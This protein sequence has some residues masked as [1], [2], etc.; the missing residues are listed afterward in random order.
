[1]PDAPA[2]SP[3][4]RAPRSSSARSNAPG[5]DDASAAADR[6]GVALADRAHAD[7]RQSLGATGTVCTAVLCTLLVPVALAAL[8]LLAGLLGP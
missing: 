2:V 1:M 5:S 3:R 4:R 7:A 8:L 6:S